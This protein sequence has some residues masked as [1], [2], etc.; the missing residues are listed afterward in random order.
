MRKNEFK[1][2]VLFFLLFS[3]LAIY[4]VMPVDA[5]P[6]LGVS[7]FDS[8]HLRDTGPTAQPV[9]RVDQLGAGK[10][11]EFMDGGTPVFSINNG[12]GIVASSILTQG[13]VI[14][15]LV[16][17][18]PTAVGTATPAAVIDNA[19]V[20]VLLDVRDSATPVFTIG[21]GGAVTGKVLAY[22]TPGTGMRCGTS[23]ITD[24]VS[25]TATV[26]AITTPVWANCSLQE[27]SGD[28][29]ACGAVTNWCV[30]G[31]PQ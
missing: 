28:A 7:N 21:Q 31:T 17:S 23:T 27:I 16:V 1:L 18:A 19:G 6:K 12:G 5:R 2:F 13:A 14:T 11:V 4:V 3:A 25:Y 29:A 20:S 15:N 9:L 26:T 22:P 24:T 30:G 8:I 10:I